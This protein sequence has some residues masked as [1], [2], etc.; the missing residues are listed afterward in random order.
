MPN[1]KIIQTIRALLAR[2]SE[3]QNNNEHE[4]NAAMRHAHRL[5]EEHAVSM[6]EVTQDEL[7]R[8]DRETIN[9]GI[10]NWKRSVV[11]LIASLY[12]CAVCWTKNEDSKH[13]GDVF[14]YGRE[15]N[16]TTVQMISDFVIESIEQE[17]NAYEERST[18]RNLDKDSFCIGALYGVRDTI[19]E[20]KK[21]RE[22]Q[23]TGGGTA[24]A[25]L[26][27]YSEWELEAKEAMN[28][29]S[30]VSTPSEVKDMREAM[31]GRS[32]GKRLRLEP[33]LEENLEKAG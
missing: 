9:T 26:N 28:V 20:L 22:E 29:N 16:R 14:I 1:D 3:D 30:Y 19:I 23:A 13:Y 7:G 21:A 33:H 15:N 27:K 8:I 11:G 5:M 12:G 10:S 18:R 24:L 25:L 6:L 32:V 17:W 31:Y 2:A 4:R